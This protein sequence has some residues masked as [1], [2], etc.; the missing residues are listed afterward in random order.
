MTH[1]L[2]RTKQRLAGCPND[3]HRVTGCVMQ[4]HAAAVIA[5]CSR[6]GVLALLLLYGG[7][8]GV[9]RAD[10]Y[11]SPL[12]W[13]LPGRPPVMSGAFGEP[14]SNHFHAGLDLSTRQ[15]VGAEVHAPAATWVE[16]VRASGGGY[17]RSI[18]LR[19]EDGRLIVFGH[20][21]AFSADVATYVDSVQR[22]TGEYEQDLRLPAQRFRYAAGARV[23]WSGQSGAGPPHLHVEVRHGDFALNP[24]LAGLSVP[25][26]VP[27]KLERLVLE[28]LDERSWVER[29]ASP[30]SYG[31]GAGADTLLVEGRVRLTLKASDA[32]NA[33]RKLPVRTVG[34]RWGD[35]W[36]ECRMDSV[37]WAGEMGQLDWL[38]DRGRVTG[39][40]GVILDAPAGWRPRF[41]RSSRPDD[42]AVELVEVAPGAPARPLELFAID[43]AGHEV[44]RR[45]WLRGPGESERG[46][47]RQASPRG[48]PIR[49]SKRTRARTPTTAPLPRWTFAILPDERVRVRVKAAPAGLHDVRIERGAARPL[50]EDVAIA[51]WD[52][53]AWCA[54]LNVSGIPDPEGLWIKGRRADSTVWWHRGTYAL[55]PM[56]TQLPVRVEDWATARIE[57]DRVYESGVV[58]VRTVPL[59][60]LAAGAAGVRAALELAPATPPLR[61]PAEVTLSLPADH[62]RDRM[63]VYRR[64]GD[65]G[66]WEWADAEWDSTARTFRAAS[67]RLGQFAMLRDTTP[68]AVRVVPPLVRPR[69]GDYSTWRLSAHA[70]DAASGVAG[71]ASAFTVDGARVPT[72]WDAEQ[73]V[74]RWRPLAAPAVGR[75]HYQLEVQD[76]VGNRTVRTGA[77]VIAS[78]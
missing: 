38:V 10:L 2:T 7:P 63:G 47:A 71:R 8:A 13:P 40:D 30:R 9:A 52:G 17:G 3:A 1:A 66:R 45:I 46:P 15:R 72:E 23:G 54:V 41:L 39:S 48:A 33:S 73:H 43:A 69:R 31:L 57:R 29:G 58:M 44:T 11:G 64:D 42:A 78:R 53:A 56:G 32:T 59:T 19:S 62:P 5:C 26:T 20:L 28:P 65:A 60:G 68:P 70:N 75:H 36:V 35:A 18:Y 76:R 37:S 25:D 27:P 6:S 74:L 21:D 24:L 34:A 22:A 67:T 61:G 4:R 16:R 55:W 49:H 50:P 12:G 14:R 77:F 51:T